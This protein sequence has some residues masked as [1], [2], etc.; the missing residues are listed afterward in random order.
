MARPR[1]SMT[2][3]EPPPVPILAMTA[4]TM[5]LAVTPGAQ[6][7][8]DD[9]GHGAERLQGQRLGREH[10]LDLGRADPERQRP[11]GSV[12][13]GVAV[14]ADHGQP[15]LGEPELRA[16]DVDDALVDVAHGEQRD[17]ELRAVAPERLHLGLAHRVGDGSGRRRD[18]VVLGRD[19]QVGPPNGATGQP[20]AVEGL[21]AGDL[22]EEVQVDVQQVGLAFGLAHHVR[23]PDLLGQ[24]PRH[25]RTSTNLPA[26]SA[27]PNSRRA[28]TCVSG[29]ETAVSVHGQL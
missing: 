7:A 11:E 6:L 20:E 19:G 1:N 2:W 14:A 9:D 18:V 12:G 21:R 15:G 4:R 3:P 17:A 22:V 23:L 28:G 8:V 10:V 13:R 26:F 27:W 16:D 24:R 29:T 5:S 25:C